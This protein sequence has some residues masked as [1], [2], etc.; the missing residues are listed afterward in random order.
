MRCC[1]N[2]G[3]DHFQR[4]VKHV[5]GAPK[6]RPRDAN[7]QGDSVRSITRIHAAGNSIRK[8]DL[9]NHVLAHDEQRLF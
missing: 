9:T 5:A 3:A 4:G 8:R 6:T 2:A 1:E 7:A